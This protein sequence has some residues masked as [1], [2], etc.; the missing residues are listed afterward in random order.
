MRI[1]IIVLVLV[2]VYFIFVKKKTSEVEKVTSTKKEEKKENKNNTFDVKSKGIILAFI[3][4]V[5][6]DY[7]N[8][9]GINYLSVRFNLR[10]FESETTYVFKTKKI[11]SLANILDFNQVSAG[12]KYLTELIMEKYNIAI[13]VDEQLFFI[14]EISRIE[15][16]IKA[17]KSVKE[18][19]SSE[20]YKRLIS[21]LNEDIIYYKNK[22]S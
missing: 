9:Y 13:P 4:E 7:Y 16:K 22:F 20:D 12:E 6:L 1:I 17:V 11:G 2:V 21:E 3:D 15:G 19:L 14:T 5:I 10:E 18:S 8:D